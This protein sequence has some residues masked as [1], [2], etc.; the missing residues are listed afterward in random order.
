MITQQWLHENCYYGSDG[1]YWQVP[2][3]G[4]TLGK[5]IGYVDPKGYR[6]VCVQINNVKKNYQEHH[7]CWLYATGSLPTNYIDHIDHN[8]DNNA[9][10]NLREATPRQ[11]S[12]NNL[13]KGYSFNKKRKKWYAYIKINAN[14]NLHLGT[15]YTKE[16]AI[17]VR[18][19]AELQYFGEFAPIR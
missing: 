1:L 11:N 15:F 18:R 9:I 6:Q 12:R 10:C 14:K 19:A 4:R 5:R 2:N 7:L 8:K 16:E 13:C 3:H 17:A